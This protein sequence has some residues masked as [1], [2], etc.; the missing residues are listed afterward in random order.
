M[1]Q[2]TQSWQNLERGWLLMM[3]ANDEA[4]RAGHALVDTDHVLLGLLSTDG[5]SAGLLRAA[6]LTLDKG[7]QAMAGLARDDLAGIGVSDEGWPVPRPDRYGADMLPFSERADQA[8]R[9]LSKNGPD[10]R[11]L[12]PLLADAHGPAAR[13][14]DAAGIDLSLLSPPTEPTAPGPG[15]TW[16]TQV[17]YVAPVPADRIWALLDDPLRRPEWDGDVAEVH[18]V[19]ESTLRAVPRF[20]IEQPRL[21]RLLGASRVTTLY[22]STYRDVGRAL[23]WEVTLP[24]RRRIRPPTHRTEILRIDLAP[25]GTTSTRLRLS[26]RTAPASGPF[27]ALHAAQT[28]MQR[29][30]LRLL[31][32]ALAQA[33]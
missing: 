15:T 8:I 14:L 23:E 20:V 11:V 29:S 24:R 1:N 32:Q 22:R 4:L 13:L 21:S 19:D 30:R 3:A 2:L 6:G 5:A 25:E 12:T 27:D 28:T 31:G 18:V 7:R 33:A 16:T 26:V 10:T 9:G 17:E